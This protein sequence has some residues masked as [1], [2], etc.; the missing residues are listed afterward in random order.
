MNNFAQYHA[1]DMVARNFVGHVNP[2]RL[3][4]Q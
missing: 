2:D 3:G 1:V 4:G